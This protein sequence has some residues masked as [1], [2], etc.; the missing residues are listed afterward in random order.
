MWQKNNQK[1]K[2]GESKRKKWDLKRKL[3]KEKKK[4]WT[5]NC[6]LEWYLTDQE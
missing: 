4:N 3:R 2:V 5:A 1:K 6:I